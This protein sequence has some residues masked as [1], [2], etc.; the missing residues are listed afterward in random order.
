M[1][2]AASIRQT[3]PDGTGWAVFSPCGGYRYQLG[4]TLTPPG[5]SPSRTCL[6][7]MLNPSTA[8][9]FQLDPTVRRCIGFASSWGCDQ[10]LVGNLFALRS[11][12]PKALYETA[13][14]VGA[15]NDSMLRELA[16]L[17]DVVVCAWGVH[18]AHQ[19]R[20]RVVRAALQPVFDLHHLGLTKDGH[21]RHPLYLPAVLTP[22]RWTA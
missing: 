18:G 2:R 15:Q 11:T 20:G 19:D 12:D 5:I 17:A 8:D 13:D 6:F 9:A 21:P 1:S 10:L 14:P 22:Q 16:E 7:L 3:S 4:R